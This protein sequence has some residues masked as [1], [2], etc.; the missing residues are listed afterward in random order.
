MAY[1]HADK[2]AAIA[3]GRTSA[4][5]G[6]NLRPATGAPAAGS[7]EPAPPIDPRLYDREDVRRI[8]AKRDIG[9]LYRVLTD[10]AGLTQRQLAELT[11]MKQSEVSDVL[12]GRRVQGYD[13]LV[14]IA[15]GLGVPRKLMGLSYGDSGAYA[16]EDEAAWKAVTEEMRR[17]SLLAAASAAAVSGPPLM[18]KLLNLPTPVEPPPL[19]SRLDMA[20]V[21][22][23]ECLTRHLRDLARE[24]GG[25]GDRVRAIAN[26]SMRL[27]AVPAP[28]PVTVRLGC[29]LAE[30]NELAGW[31]CADSGHDGSAWHYF[32]RAVTLAGKVRD[33]FQV[34][35]TLRYAGAI[36]REQGRPDDA[37][38]LFQLGQIRLL[39]APKDDPQKTVVTAWLESESALALADMEHPQAIKH[40]TRA[41]DGWEPP[42]S[43]ERSG[44]DELTAR[45]YLDLGHL[46]VAEPYAAGAVRAWGSGERR[47]GVLADITLATIH[48]RAGEPDGLALAKKAIDGVALL[49][50]VRARVRWLEP[51]VAALESRPG[52]DY[53]QLARMARQVAA[54]RV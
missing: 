2:I 48:V 9:G 53:Q 1:G 23:I 30:L 4:E 27:C 45:V 17:R 39:T 5:L 32:E 12:K 8:L 22:E 52:G 25:Q 11:G 41:R 14:R 51:L 10:D 44:M 38:K 49:R 43:F 36:E 40:L 37:L 31:C 15:E 47:N 29:A 42:D 28:E 33:A 6:A 3:A 18:G 13:V 19:P 35:S 21:V 20:D 7:E 34:A 46:D 50:S 16:R 26:Q 24:R 54:T